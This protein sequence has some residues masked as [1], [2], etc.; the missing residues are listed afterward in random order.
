ME[1]AVERIANLKARE[2]FRQ[3]LAAE[4]DGDQA[5][6]EEGYRNAIKLQPDTAIFHYRL[7]LLLQKQSQWEAASGSMKMALGL[8]TTNEALRQRL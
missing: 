6:A 5:G 1:A 8:E 3:A 4:K 2:V 7:G